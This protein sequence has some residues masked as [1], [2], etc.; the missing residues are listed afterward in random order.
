MDAQDADDPKAILRELIA[1]AWCEKA[2]S[3]TDK[4]SSWRRQ[5]EGMRM[6]ELLSRAE[7]CGI[8]EEALCAAQESEH[9]KMAVVEMLMSRDPPSAAGAE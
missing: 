1:Q 3:D 4:A 9:P 5:L 2:N 8:G 7:E 6:R